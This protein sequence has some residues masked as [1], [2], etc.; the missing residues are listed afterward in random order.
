MLQ[1]KF[2]DHWTSASGGDDFLRFL[3]YMGVAAMFVM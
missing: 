2:Q 1:E 3:S